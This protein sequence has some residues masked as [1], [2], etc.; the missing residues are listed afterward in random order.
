MGDVIST[1]VRG[2]L[3]VIGVIVLVALIWT[4]YIHRDA[5]A[6]A[7]EPAANLVQQLRGVSKAADPDGVAGPEPTADPA[8]NSDVAP[9][10]DAPT[11]S[12]TPSTS[13]GASS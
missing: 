10:T 11:D 6:S 2:L 4:T 3:G 13:S 9:N 8:P 5:L 1:F 12:D 7:L